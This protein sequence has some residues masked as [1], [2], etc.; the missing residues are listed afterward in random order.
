MMTSINP[1]DMALSP[2]GGRRTEFRRPREP[3]QSIIRDLVPWPEP[4]RAI[5]RGK[6]GDFLPSPACGGGCRAKARRVGALSA[7]PTA[8]RAPTPALR[9]SFARLD[10]RKRER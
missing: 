3:E 6:T 2:T 10:P 5:G 1:S 4:G 8:E 9:A 7:N